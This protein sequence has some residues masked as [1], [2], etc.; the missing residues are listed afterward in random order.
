VS[1]P[2]TG[3]P[4]GHIRTKFIAAV[5]AVALLIVGAVVSPLGEKIVELIWPSEAEAVLADSV[6]A[7]AGC[8]SGG[9]PVS[10]SLSY[11]FRGSWWATPDKL[12]AT[13]L[14]ELNA[15]EATDEV[16]TP[17]RP[18]RSAERAGTPL[19][20]AI[21]GCGA[22]AVVITGMRPTVSKR[23]APLAGSLVRSQ[24][25]GEIEVL[26]IGFDL[27]AREPEALTFDGR[28]LTFGGP[29]F[30]SKVIEVKP[31]ETIPIS[32]MAVT[33]KS[34]V[35]WTVAFDTL[36]D[37]NAWT[38]SVTPPGGAPVRSNA[39]SEH[40]RSAYNLDFA[41]R[42]RPLWKAVKPSAIIPALRAR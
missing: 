32:V 11:D 6:T 28:M 10:V 2:E 9:P 36:V 13:V 35:E 12:P 16:L 24:G 18:V 20:L 3:A 15:S 8:T 42:P 25:Q 33:K 31:G 5:G 37:G 34:Y 7:G 19:R 1:S 39:L 14:D 30:D 4:A 29:Y 38:F 26:D 21:T 23:E 17:H 22:K 41:A 40:Y 27:D